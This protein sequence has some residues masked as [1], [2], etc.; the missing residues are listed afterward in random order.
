[1]AD[2]CA[3]RRFTFIYRPR[4]NELGPEGVA[5]TAKGLPTDSLIHEITRQWRVERPD[6]DLRNFL[7]QIYLQRIGRIIESRFGK[8]CVRR[9]GVRAQD[10]RLLFALRR[11]GAPFSKRPTDLF[12]ATLVTSGAITK[13][14][15]RLV[16]KKL[17]RRLPDP[18]YRGGFLVQ[19]TEKGL[20]VIDRAST[21]I[22]TESFIG[23]AM[24]AMKPSERDAAEQFCLG[25]IATLEAGSS[26]PG[27]TAE[28]GRSRRPVPSKSRNK[29][30]IR[31]RARA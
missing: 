17:V 30:T 25:L 21:I 29:R 12:K 10:M 16:N 27:K 23:P 26:A 7:L 5:V 11:G 19:L 9:F 2:C 28:T 22:A 20:D 24:A 14:V 4:R 8:M 15:D 31:R 3:H 1:L 18:D 13:Q 6:L